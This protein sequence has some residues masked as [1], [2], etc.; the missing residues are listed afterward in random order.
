M[1]LGNEA[2][3]LQ[4]SAARDSLYYL[5]ILQ[6]HSRGGLF[7]AADRKACV[8]CFCFRYYESAHRPFS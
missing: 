1:K 2:S 4:R 7:M 5:K 8:T 3:S 6:S